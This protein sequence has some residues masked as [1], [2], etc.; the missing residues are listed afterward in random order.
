MEIEPVSIPFELKHVN[1]TLSMENVVLFTKAH[2]LN[3]INRFVDFYFLN[4]SKLVCEGGHVR[5]NMWEQVDWVIY[6]VY[7]VWLNGFAA[8]RI[9]RIW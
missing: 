6:L 9:I 5:A 7:L 2:L 3:D 1:N 4:F 8:C